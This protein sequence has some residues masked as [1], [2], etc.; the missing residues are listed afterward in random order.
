MTPRSRFGKRPSKFT[1]PCTIRIEHT[2]E[3]LEAHVELDNGVEPGIGDRVQVHGAPLSV[4]FGQGLVVR[5][6]ATVT[7][8]NGLQRAW[9]GFQAMFILTELYEV[10]FSEG[11]L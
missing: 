5:R 3:S 10:S 6:Q 8:A 9:V 2:Y 11:R 4:P 7:R 1:I